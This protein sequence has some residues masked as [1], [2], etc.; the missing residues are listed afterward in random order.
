MVHVPVVRVSEG[1]SQSGSPWDLPNTL[2]MQKSVAD[3]GE[4]G[5]HT[6]TANFMCHLDWAQGCLAGKHDF[7]VWRLRVFLAKV[8]T[9]TS[10]PRKGDCSHQ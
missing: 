8:P 5:L 6:V 3:A 7:W 1:G 4:W 2:S 10:R 9:E